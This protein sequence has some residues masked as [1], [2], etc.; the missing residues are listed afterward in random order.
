MVWTRFAPAVAELTLIKPTDELF[1]TFSTT[2]GKKA[3]LPSCCWM[4][5][6]PVPVLTC[7]VVPGSAAPSARCPG[8][9]GR[10]VLTPLRCL[11]SHPQPGG[12]PLWDLISR[13][14]LLR[15]RGVE[16][17]GF[18]V[19]PRSPAGKMLGEKVERG[20]EEAPLLTPQLRCHCCA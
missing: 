19:C 5:T 18:V 9:W 14:W 3:S 11:Q 12:G 1:Y 13:M 15:Q 2:S 6:Q 16:G 8:C 20:N 7:V 17:S 10:A 4:P